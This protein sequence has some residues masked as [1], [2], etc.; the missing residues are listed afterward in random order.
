MFSCFR[1][2]N[3]FSKPIIS[4]S[5]SIC[6]KNSGA[7]RNNELS[8]K[9]CFAITD[10]LFLKYNCPDDVLPFKTAR[11]TK[12]GSTSNHNKTTLIQLPQP[13]SE[14]C[15]F[16]TAQ[17]ILPH[18]RKNSLKS[19]LSNIMNVFIYFNLNIIQ[20]GSSCYT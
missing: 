5:N 14:K 13:Q 2:A 18:P 12:M 6:I 15:P 17:S 7:A 1:L 10:W 3:S 19:L 20:L 16:Q 9:N 4:N 8:P 11:I